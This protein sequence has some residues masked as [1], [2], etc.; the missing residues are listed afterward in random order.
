VTYFLGER[1]LLSECRGL[2]DLVE[3]PPNLPRFAGEGLLF[4]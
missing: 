4:D 3:P 1:E 2:D